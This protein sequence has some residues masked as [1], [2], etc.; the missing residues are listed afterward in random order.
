MLKSVNAFYD[1]IT[2]IGT[3]E[4]FR[5]TTFEI[6]DEYCEANASVVR[7]AVAF[8]LKLDR[9]GNRLCDSI[10]FDFWDG[11]SWLCEYEW[12]DWN[13]NNKLITVAVIDEYST[14]V[15]SYKTDKASLQRRLLAILP[16]KS[17]A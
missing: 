16:K 8:I 11:T 7:K 10:R 13:R 15:D 9:N 1:E 2:P 4:L 3:R 6:I 17:V 12:D 5:I 14:T